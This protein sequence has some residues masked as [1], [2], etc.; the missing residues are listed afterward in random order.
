MM[1]IVVVV[2]VSLAEV[3]QLSNGVRDRSIQALRRLLNKIHFL[4]LLL[5]EVVFFFL[6]S[7]TTATHLMFLQFS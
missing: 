6:A 2:V 3:T 7:A 4:S 1:M 5:L